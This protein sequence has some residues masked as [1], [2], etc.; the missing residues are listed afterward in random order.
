M[1]LQDLLKDV[2]V[3]EMKADP[4]LEITDVVYDT[5]KQI[6]PGNLFVA[7]KG[8]SFDGN[9]YIPAA[10]EKGAAAIV[11]ATKPEADI[12]YILVESDRLALALIG[13]TGTEG[14]PK[15]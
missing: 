8:F 6:L 15:I 11:T 2:P 12:P 5:R 4:G 1:K 7:I 14:L 13:A 3:L 9:S 10:L